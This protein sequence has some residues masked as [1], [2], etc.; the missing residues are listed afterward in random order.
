MGEVEM[1]L[2][3]KVTDL[4]AHVDTD[5]HDDATIRRMVDGVV[6]CVLSAMAAARQSGRDH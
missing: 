2:H 3:T 5:E 1:K 6:A 4:L